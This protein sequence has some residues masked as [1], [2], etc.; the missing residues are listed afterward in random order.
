MGRNHSDGIQTLALLSV[1]LDFGRWSFLS[2]LFLFRTA[3]G[4][5]LAFSHSPRED[6]VL[7]KEYW[8]SL[9]IWG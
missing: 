6:M 2:L 8:E 4:T 5:S 9:F 1:T 7:E 3:G